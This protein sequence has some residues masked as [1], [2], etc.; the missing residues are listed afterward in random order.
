VCVCVCV[1]VNS[2]NSQ[3]ATGKGAVH[4]LLIAALSNL[5]VTDQQRMDN[6]VSRNECSH[7]VNLTEQG[8]QTKNFNYEINNS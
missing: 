8:N 5:K 4:G 1:C 6:H 2:V 7:F 3:A